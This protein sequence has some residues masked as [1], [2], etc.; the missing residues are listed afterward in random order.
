MKH[1]NPDALKLVYWDEIQKTYQL[2][3]Y[4]FEQ[5]DIIKDGIVSI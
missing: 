5:V 1:P 4:F 3:S 2:L